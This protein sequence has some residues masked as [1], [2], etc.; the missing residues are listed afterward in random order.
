MSPGP[1][2]RQLADVGQKVVWWRAQLK[3]FACAAGI[4]LLIWGFSLLDLW[5]QYS[6]GGRF[7]IWLAL[8]S[9]VA[10]AVWFVM[11]TL[12][13]TLSP[14]A[15][16][17]KIE[18]AFPDLD[19]HLINYLQFLAGDDPFKKAYV[20]K[21]PPSLHEVE[22]TEMKNQR[23]H[24]RVTIALAVAAVLLLLPGL[25]LGQAWGIAVWRVVNPFS[26]AEPATLTK[27]LSV[28]PGDTTVMQGTPLVLTCSVRG[29]KGHSVSVDVH[30][31][32][33]DKT[34]YSLGS[35]A[36]ESE[37]EEFSY[38]IPQVNTRL[39]YRF[40]AGD[41]A[42]PKWYTVETRPPLAFSEL[43]AKVIPPSYT[44]L[45]TKKYDALSEPLQV[46]MGSRVEF[47]PRSNLPLAKLTLQRGEE[48][49]A[50][51]SLRDPTAWKGNLLMTD[52]VPP[53]LIAV[54]TEGDKIEQDIRFS[55]E[56]DRLPGIEI[57]APEGR[58]VLA[59]GAR[60]TISFIVADDYGISEISVERVIPGAVRKARGEVLKTWRLS[61]QKEFTD[62]W[63]DERWHS[64]DE[65]VLAYRITARDNCPFDA[66]NRV[67]RSAAI[68]FNS[69]S[70][71]T[72]AAA[73]EKLEGQAFAV[74]SQ[75]IELQREN[76]AKTEMYKS[77]L[78]TSTS[79]QWKETAERQKRIRIM[80]KELLSNPLDPLGNLTATA[81]KLYINEMAQVIPLLSGVLNNA[82]AQRPE[83]VKKALN[84]ENKI[85][86]GLTYADVAAAKSKVQRRVAALASMLARIIREETSIIK[87]TD[88]YIKE[89]GKV[90]VTLVDRQ[91]ELALDLTDFVDSCKKESAQV[92]GNDEGYGKLLMQVAEACESKKVRDDMLLAA[93]KLDENEA[94]EALPYE[95]AALEKLKQLQ[96]MMD[97]I[98]MEEQLEQEEAMLEAIEEARARFEKLEDL[99]RKALENMEMVKDQLDKSDKDV[100]MLE[101]EYQEL[102]ENTKE[103]LLQVPTDLNIFMELNVANDIV[104]DVFSVF[105]EVEQIPGSENLGAGDVSE[106]ALGKREEYLEGMEE[107]KDRLDDLESWLMNKPDSLKVT[108]EPFD[109]EEM[110]EA[111]I[112]LGA[113]STAAEELIGDLLEK[114]EE[115]SEEADDGA[116]NT[117][118]PDT[119]ASQEVKEGDV[120]SFGAKGKSGN[121]TPDHKE[122]DGRSNVGRQGMAVGETAAGSGTINEGDKNIEE[123][124]TQDPTQSGQID[125]DGEDIDTKAT[126]G[127][128]LA[129]GKAE[130][131]GMDGGVERM[132]SNEA[133]STEGLD[134]LLAEKSDS[135]FAKASMQNVRAD[136]LKNAAHHLRQASDAIAKGNIAQLK[137]HRKMALASL[138]KAKAQINAAST[139]SF[140]IEK[141]SSLLD[142]V[143]EGGPELAPAKYRA[144][145]SEYYKALNNGL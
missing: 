57:V 106:R 20:Q 102:L 59:S 103:A 94:A 33:K 128:K 8:V 145:V 121:E 46:A 139:G 70:V 90:G 112:S 28:E 62:T 78:A 110:P 34:S 100:D 61:G 77:I 113:L 83:Q 93:E 97:Q 105:E 12:A 109:K 67:A 48:E 43:V 54:G 144:L 85:L 135:L 35:V 41:A 58:P 6:R 63:I 76:I 26:N 56:M 88:T 92:V 89:S 104:E 2:K 21:G 7:A 114:S 134:D 31:D 111:G 1:L 69:P 74:L 13:R 119:V 55:F 80:T 141:K 136:A 125:I 40:R 130:S 29:Y 84:M 123:R 116:I 3:M 120:T 10:A 127:G 19:N 27:I 30:P 79:E 124:R 98:Q 16:A 64:R 132:D 22:I 23:A 82:T 122:Q 18:K 47:T 131:F 143:V 32:D 138:K 66:S 14:E 9:G 51:V 53:R 25:F 118:V 129:T 81:K 52:A 107:A 142:D 39:R 99:H 95:K 17:A 65:N 72:A 108:T 60:P 44:R 101:E 86:R 73:R 75:V 96:A 36:G 37:G 49:L 50:M 38:R 117:S 115:M 11:N 91:D 5:L 71:K 87:Q 42:F 4:I 68:V 126:G 15:V 137:E 24:R 133:G 45:S 140:S